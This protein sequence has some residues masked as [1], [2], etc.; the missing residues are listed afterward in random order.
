[1]PLDKSLVLEKV[2]RAEEFTAAEREDFAR[3]LLGPLGV[4]MLATLLAV[5]EGYKEQIANFNFTSPEGVAG[6]TRA[7]G[8][9]QALRK[10]FDAILEIGELQDDNATN[11]EQ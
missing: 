7:Q 10:A 6:A 2:L 3:F 1:M 11:T 4:K 8:G 5:E 9:Y